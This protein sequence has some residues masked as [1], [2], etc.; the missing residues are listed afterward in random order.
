VKYDTNNKWQKGVYF[1]YA[2]VG[3]VWWSS[4]TFWQIYDSSIRSTTLVCLCSVH[5]G[6]IR[7]SGNAVSIPATVTIQD[8]SVLVWTSVATSNYKEENVNAFP[9]LLA[10]WLH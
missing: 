2:Q 6:A 10:L 3:F 9:L 7:I 4:I 1:L 8:N 5:A